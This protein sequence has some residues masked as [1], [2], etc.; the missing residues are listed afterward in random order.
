VPS[1]TYYDVVHGLAL[2]VVQVPVVRGVLVTATA[3]TIVQLVPVAAYNE[4]A[5]VPVHVD[6]IAGM[7]VEY[8]P[9]LRYLLSNKE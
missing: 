4:L 6:P 8:N 1:L 3:L 5:V 7:T 2:V 9:K